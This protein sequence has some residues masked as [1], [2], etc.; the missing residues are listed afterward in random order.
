MS[1]HPTAIVDKDA[2]IGKNVDIGAYSVVEG[3][4]TIGDDTRLWQNVYVAR[5]TTIGKSNQVHM[6]AVLG[7]EPQDRA[8]S[9]KPSYLKIGDRNII[10]EFV[11]IHRG[12]QEGSETVVG[13][14]NFIMGLCHIAHNCKLGNNITMCNSSLLAGY[15]EVGDMV[16]MSGNCVAHQFVRLGKL[17]MVGGSGRIGKDVPPF[18]VVERSSMVVSYNIVGIRRAGFDEN[19][20]SEI[21]KAFNI[22][23]RSELNVKNAVA[24]IENELHSPEIRYFVDF[25]RSSEKRGICRYGGRRTSDS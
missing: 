6:G 22:L 2:K 12:T 13:D 18:M 11:T 7:H 20:K 4:V 5:G 24:K 1:I 15:V 16:F 3:G 21:K 25:I 19:T 14:D 23:Y 9:G 17:V 10:R 8:F